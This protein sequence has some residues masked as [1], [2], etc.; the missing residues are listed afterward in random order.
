MFEMLLPPIIFLLVLVF[1]VYSLRKQKRLSS[2][3]IVVVLFVAFFIVMGV[4]SMY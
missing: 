3:G 2:V 1:I 4:V